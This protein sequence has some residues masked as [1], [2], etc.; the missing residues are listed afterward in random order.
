MTNDFDDHE[1][2]F[3]KVVS[4]RVTDNLFM[5]Q[6]KKFKVKKCKSVNHNFNCNVRDLNCCAR[7]YS[8]GGAHY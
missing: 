3:E 2:K 4:N 6:L 7:P 5:N 1:K 8:R